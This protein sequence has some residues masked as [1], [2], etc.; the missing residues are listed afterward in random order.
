MV[1]RTSLA[2]TIRGRR[3]LAGAV[4]ALMLTGYGLTGCGVVSSVNKVRHDVASNRATVDQFTSTLKSS[5][6][7]TFEVTYVTTGSAPSTIVYAVRPPKG[8]AFKDIPSASSGS[9][10]DTSRRDIVANSSGEYSCSPP[11]SPGSASSSRWACQKLGT[12]DAAARNAIFSIY[13]P[14]HWVAVLKGFSVAAGFAGATITSSRMTVH[15]FSLKCVDFH[16]PG[17]KGSSRICTTAQ[18]ILGYVKVAPDPTSFEITAYTTSPP[19]SLFELP[20]GA[21]IAASQGATG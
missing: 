16:A 5:E 15:G 1:A 2:V 20:P 13:T 7:T 8:L 3:P 4:A 9:G 17:I 19:A 14:G 18:G 6:A 12:A 21:R 10:A 11:S